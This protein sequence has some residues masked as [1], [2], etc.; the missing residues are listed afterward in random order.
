MTAYLGRPCLTCRQAELKVLHL[1]H[2]ILYQREDQHATQ[3]CLLHNTWIPS[4]G[5]VK[6]AGIMSVFLI[7]MIWLQ[8]GVA[9]SIHSQGCAPTGPK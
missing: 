3:C 5:Y 7:R 1:D 8:W 2:L 9:H 4:I 6:G